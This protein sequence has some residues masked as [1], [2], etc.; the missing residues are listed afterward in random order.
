MVLPTILYNFQCLSFIRYSDE[1]SELLKKNTI[2]IS[3]FIF[4]VWILLFGSWENFVHVKLTYGSKAACKERRVRQPGA[5][6]FC[7]RASEF[8]A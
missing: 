7:D 4:F 8:C 6:G 1:K 5:S 3:E 2:E